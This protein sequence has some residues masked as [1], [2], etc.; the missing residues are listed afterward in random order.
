M[1]CLGNICRSPMAEGIMRLKIEQYELAATVD[2]A[3]TS[4]YHEGEHPDKR[5]I[6]NGKKHNVDISQLVSRPFTIADFE[7]FDVIYAMDS[8]N[9][10][11]IIRLA[12]NENDKAK[13]KLIL[14]E[15]YPATNKAVPDPYF[16]GEG[17]FENVFNLLDEACEVIAKKIKQ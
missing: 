7:Q 12:R 11:N 5:S 3:G 1:V 2:S 14:N 17:G 6:L 4:N 8:E 10:K 15:I 16:G 13:V 9:M